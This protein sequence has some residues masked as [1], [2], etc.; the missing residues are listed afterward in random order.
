MRASLHHLIRTVVCVALAS[1]AAGRVAF[2][3][4]D[5]RPL[6]IIQTTELRLKDPLN[7]E[8]P[9][10]GEVRLLVLVDDTGRLTDLMLLGST[11]RAFTEMAVEGLQQWR[12]E[13]ARANG[14]AVGLR[15]TVR[16]FFGSHGRVISVRGG[17][18]LAGLAGKPFAFE[19]SDRQV[20]EQ[21]LDHPL[22]ATHVVRPLFPAQLAGRLTGR[23]PVVIDFFVD[24]T[25]RPRMPVIVSSTHPELSLAA[26]D[27]ID[28]WRFDP[29]THDGRP[30]IVRAKQVFVFFESAAQDT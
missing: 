6:K 9:A 12:F 3:A 13:P 2:G 14:Q 17:D 23:T 29:P 30:A 24:E 27:A 16:I 10:T 18:V 25:G 21:N 1:T 20:D 5:D 8:V 7:P 28:Q 26:L 19:F 4:R 15:T 11:H 22:R